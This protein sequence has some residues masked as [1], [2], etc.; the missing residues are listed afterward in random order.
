MEELTNKEEKDLKDGI[1]YSKKKSLLE[2][3]K[4]LENE[5]TEDTKGPTSPYIT[6]L[7]WL[8]LF[9]A[10]GIGITIG[11]YWMQKGKTPVTVPTNK[12]MQAFN[13]NF[14][15]YPTIGLVR[16]NE[17]KTLRSE[18]LQAY[19]SNDFTKAISKFE[20]LEKE[21][22]WNF[23]SPIDQ[24]ILMDL[25]F[26]GIAYIGKGEVDKGIEKLELF[27]THSSVLQDQAKFYIA[28]GYL[29]QENVIK[30]TEIKNT[31]HSKETSGK[32][33]AYFRIVGVINEVVQKL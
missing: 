30:F 3:L 26:S 21:T 7:K 17:T 13:Q 31:F 32:V 5:L 1:I 12:Y 9:L 11:W 20:A 15:A 2:D 25:F 22:D 28:M 18:A 10:L 14:E 33:R 19:S 29:R 16:N 24:T 23:N 6:Y 4:A 27:R 8:L